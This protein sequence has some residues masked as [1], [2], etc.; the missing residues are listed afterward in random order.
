PRTAAP[1]ATPTQRAQSSRRSGFSVLA[2]FPPGRAAGTG[3]RWGYGLAG[4]PRLSETREGMT[5][6]PPYPGS[7]GSRRRAGPRRTPTRRPHGNPGAIQTPPA[8]EG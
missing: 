8:T 3:A 1:F 7:P 6:A 4:R 2:T 5:P